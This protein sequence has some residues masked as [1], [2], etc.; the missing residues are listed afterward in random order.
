MNHLV[1]VDEVELGKDQDAVAVERRLEGV[2]DWCLDLSAD[3]KVAE[4]STILELERPR[5][6][7]SGLADIRRMF[8]GRGQCGDR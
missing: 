4:H 7:E 8:A 6:E 3:L 5:R 1:A 2:A